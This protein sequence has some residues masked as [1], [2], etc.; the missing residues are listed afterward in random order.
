[1]TEFVGVDLGPG[2][3]LNI[4]P[5]S[6]L[7]L[8]SLRI[9]AVEYRSTE[10]LGY[11]SNVPALQPPAYQCVC[12]SECVCKCVHVWDKTSSISPSPLLHYM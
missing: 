2:E 7:G 9:L 1:M 3:G 12:V 10:C 8:V 5:F 11:G 4:P 6:L